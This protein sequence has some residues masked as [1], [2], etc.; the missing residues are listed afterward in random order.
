[1]PIL[2]RRRPPPSFRHRGS[3]AE[4][5]DVDLILRKRSDFLDSTARHDELFLMDGAWAALRKHEPQVFVGVPWYGA[6]LG[7]L[8]PIL[9][10]PGRPV[11][12]WSLHHLGW[13]RSP[14]APWGRGVGGEGESLLLRVIR[15]VAW[16]ASRQR[17]DAL[18]L[19]LFENDPLTAIVRPLTLTRWGIPPGGAMLHAAGDLAPLVLQSPRP[20]ILSGQ[21][22]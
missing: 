18:V 17:A 7:R 9:P 22:A 15:S 11:T 19:P 3:A 2:E 13:D 8:L 1:V 5:A 6:L 21:D 16:L 4:A 10:V 20:L 12:V 14:L